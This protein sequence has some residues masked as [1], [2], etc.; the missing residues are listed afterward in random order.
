MLLET[1]S[2]EMFVAL[3]S[4][5]LCEMGFAIVGYVVKDAYEHLVGEWPPV[6]RVPVGDAGHEVAAQYRAREVKDVRV[7]I[8]GTIL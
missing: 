3:G 4:P 7:V 6:K 2:V 8:T 1:G 5:V